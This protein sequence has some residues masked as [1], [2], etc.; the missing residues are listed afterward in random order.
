V[1]ALRPAKGK[2]APIREVSV[3]ADRARVAVRIVVPDA[4][5]RGTYNGFLLDAKTQEPRGTL[6]LVV[7]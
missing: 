1:S 4:Q 3:R 6:S 2:A 5:P 7:R